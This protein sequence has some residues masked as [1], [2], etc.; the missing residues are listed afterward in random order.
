M[1]SASRPVAPFDS[2]SPFGRLRATLSEGEGSGRPEQRRG[3]T[4]EVGIALVVAVLTVAILSGLGLSL[5]LTLSIE[6]RAGANQRA[7]ASSLYAADAAVEAAALEMD[8]VGD[9]NGVLSGLVQSSRTDG[10][11]SGA[12]GLPN[13]ETVDISALTDQLTCG[14]PTGCTDSHRTTSTAERPW[15]ANNPIW[16]PFLFGTPAGVG[17]THLDADYII[18]W[19]GDDG[20]ETDEDP[21]V[22][23]GGEGGE[24]RWL[25]RLRALTIGPR[26]A[27][28]ALEAVIARRCDTASG[29]ERCEVGS[30]VQSWRA[31]HG[32]IP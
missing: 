3:A 7:A 31:V 11:P 27:R 9:W 32:S 30:R 6:P 25:L 24:G 20:M 14:R 21:L 13:G 12:R 22:D 29:E 16:R 15:G 17:L 5:L 19:V 4:S 1:S 28:Q 2:R 23:G 10:A 26:G 8:R 18:V